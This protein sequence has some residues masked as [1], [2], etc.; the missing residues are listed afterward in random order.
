M[1][2][3]IQEIEEAIKSVFE[4]SQIANTENVYEHIEDSDDYKLIIFFNNIY[5]KEFN[6]IYTKLIFVTN[7][8][9]SLIKNNSFLYLFDINCVYTSIN[10]DSVEDF[11]K[12]LTDI[13]EN[14]KFGDNIKSL[15][16]FIQA[17]AFF[18]NEWFN[19]NGVNNLN[20]SNIKYNPTSYVMPC[21]SLYFSFIITIKNSDIEF[22]ITKEKDNLFNFSF[23]I[24]DKTINIEKPNL[25][26]IIETVGDVLRN[27]L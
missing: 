19:K 21:K 22:I 27:N 9:K 24:Y 1:N 25:K 10:F 26:Y 14:R 8:E 2:I 20:V 18:V 12:K 4:K 5:Q 23:K 16:K 13:F 7:S 6:L 3:T 11:K 17:P 15:S